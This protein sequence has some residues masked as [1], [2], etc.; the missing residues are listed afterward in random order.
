MSSGTDG[1]ETQV[2]SRS[3]V[4]IVKSDAGH[5]SGTGRLPAPRQMARHHRVRN[6][7]GVQAPS[8]QDG[9]DFRAPAGPAQPW[10]EPQGSGHC[11]QPAAAA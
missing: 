8:T 7:A 2:Q 5:W 4:S 9:A 11:G 3:S 1:P 10:Q 6:A